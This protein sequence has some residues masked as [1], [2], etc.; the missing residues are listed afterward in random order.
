M[1]E[2]EKFQNNKK[3]QRQPIINSLRDLQDDLAPRETRTGSYEK[4][5]FG[6]RERVFRV[7]TKNKTK[8]ESQGIAL[9]EQSQGNRA[10]NK[11][12][13][14]REMEIGQNR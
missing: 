8:K 2:A 12:K 13:K 4:G 6:D 7:A 11:R 3:Q 9:K 14:N 10:D 1:Q 5:T